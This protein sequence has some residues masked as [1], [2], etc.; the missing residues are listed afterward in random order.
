MASQ[1]EKLN[2]KLEGKQRE[3][4]EARRR[5]SEAR[6]GYQSRHIVSDVEC[7]GEDE[8]TSPL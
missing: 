4:L 1:L 7:E 3:A 2:K 8:M 5:K 6:A